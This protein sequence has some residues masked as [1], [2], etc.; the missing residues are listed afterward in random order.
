LAN[1]YIESLDKGRPARSAKVPIQAI[2]SWMKRVGIQGGNKVAY[3]IQN[4]IYSKGIK[5]RNFIKKANDKVNKEVIKLVDKYID[6][7]LNKL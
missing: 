1:S 3:K 4:S 2:V 5:P 6:N 7:K